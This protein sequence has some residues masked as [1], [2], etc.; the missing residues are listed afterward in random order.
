MLAGVQDV[1]G[2]E[3][4]HIPG[5]AVLLPA[6]TKLLVVNPAVRR[7][8]LLLQRENVVVLGG[9]VR[10]LAAAP[11]MFPVHAGSSSWLSPRVVPQSFCQEAAAAGHMRGAVAA[12]RERSSGPVVL[13]HHPTCEGRCSCPLFSMHS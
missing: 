8:V 3:Y 10:G 1:V 11:L 9:M 13:D 12:T 2:L 7:G 5:L 6:G 4:R